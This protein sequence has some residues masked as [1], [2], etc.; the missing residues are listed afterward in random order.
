MHLVA[1]EPAPLWQ[2][3]GRLCQYS[4]PEQL[5]KFRYRESSSCLSEAARYCEGIPAVFESIDSLRILHP[6]ALE[7]YADGWILVVD[8]FASRPLGGFLGRPLDLSTFLPIA[9]DPT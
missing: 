1:Y 7:Q 6:Q 2:S 5:P 3:A 9:H 4:R 8:D